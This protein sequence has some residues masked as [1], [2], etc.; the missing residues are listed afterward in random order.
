M[1][2]FFDWM[3][4]WRAFVRKSVETYTKTKAFNNS[5]PLRGPGLLNLMSGTLKRG[6]INNYPGETLP[7]SGCQPNQKE[8]FLS[9]F[10]LEAGI[11]FEHYSLSEISYNGRPLASGSVDNGIDVKLI[12]LQQTLLENVFTDENDR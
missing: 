7:Y 12:A 8:W 2:P 4:S 5:T 3:K 6:L 9:R 1:E 10:S 11:Y